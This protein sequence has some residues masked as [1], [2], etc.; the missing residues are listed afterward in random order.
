MEGG[1]DEEI[2]DSGCR[3]TV[4]SASGGLRASIDQRELKRV[5]AA[6]GSEWDDDQ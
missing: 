5:N 4:R 3:D 6:V 2:T 1:H